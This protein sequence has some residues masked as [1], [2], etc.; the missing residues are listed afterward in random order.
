MEPYP[1]TLLTDF[2]AKARARE[3]A[4]VYFVGRSPY[5]L[6]LTCE[7]DGHIEVNDEDVPNTRKYPTIAAAIEG[8]GLKDVII[9]IIG[10]EQVRRL[11]DGSPV[12]RGRREPHQFS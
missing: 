11:L 8:E 7:S 10:D 6:D 3:R 1:L 9:M 5:S 12:R 4:T 2:F